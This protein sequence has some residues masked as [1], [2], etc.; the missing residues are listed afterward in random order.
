MSCGI[1]W[2]SESQSSDELEHHDWL[3]SGFGDSEIGYLFASKFLLDF[4]NMIGTRG[5]LMYNLLD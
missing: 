1:Q 2:A 3:F 5:S 4:Y